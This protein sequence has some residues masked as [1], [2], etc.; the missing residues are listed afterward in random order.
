MTGTYTHVQKRNRAINQDKNAKTFWDRC[1]RFYTRLQEHQAQEL[2]CTLTKRIAPFLH[3]QMR[4]LEVGCGTGQISLPLAPLVSDWTAT[5]LSSRMIAELQ[6]RPLPTNLYPAIQD[7]T[8]LPYDALQF[9]AVVMANTLHIMPEPEQ[10]L[11]E[12][13]RVLTH[14]GL[15]IAPTFIKDEHQQRWK[16]WVMERLGFKIFL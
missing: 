1:A 13:H 10:A 4:V 9:D 7:A 16:L 14:D 11:R 5:D 12:I 6:K 3:P 2:Y 8:H 15:L